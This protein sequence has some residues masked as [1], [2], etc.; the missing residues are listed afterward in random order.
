ME[1]RAVLEGDEV[2]DAADEAEGERGELW[3]WVGEPEVADGVAVGVA[4]GGGVQAREEGLV[5][6]GGGGGVDEELVDLLGWG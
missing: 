6:K 1:V 5:G 2:V 4:C 3:V